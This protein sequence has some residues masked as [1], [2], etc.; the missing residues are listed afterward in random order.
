MQTE[1]M[2]CDHISER[3]KSLV[4][5]QYGMSFLFC[6]IHFS[7]FNIHYSLDATG[8]LMNNEY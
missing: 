1:V 7:L 8:F 3:K 5:V 6:I 4:Q 2:Q